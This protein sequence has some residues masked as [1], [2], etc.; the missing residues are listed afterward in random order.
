MS[1][2]DAASVSATGLS[3]EAAARTWQRPR[4][5]A[6]AWIRRAAW[7]GGALY[8][9]V[10]VATL[11]VDFERMAAGVPRAAEFVSGFF[12]PDF[13]TRG[14]D[15]IEGFI[16][17]VTMTLLS[18]V[19]GVALSI[20]LAIGAARNFA[21]GPVYLVCRSIIA[22]SRT[23]PEVMIAIFFV[24]MFGF[25]PFAGLITLIVGTVGFLGKLLAEEIE[26]CS[27]EQIEAIRATGASLPKILVFGLFPQVFPRLVGLGLYRLDINFRESA[28][29]G[30]VGAGGIG[31]T[32]STTLNRYE[33]SSAAAVLVLIIVIVLLTENVSG[34]IRQRLI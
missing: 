28:I 15:I 25:G 27:T 30:V 26:G 12:W 8:L 2:P 4:L 17:S 14:G 18:T 16:E 7:G 10:A 20:P 6:N 31:A 32:L 21:S 9:I 29:I 3:G 22:V 13:T 19:I 24:V 1:P 33:F 34:F 11:G 5:I 23:F